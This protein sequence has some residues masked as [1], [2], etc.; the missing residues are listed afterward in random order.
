MNLKN[1]RKEQFK[2]LFDALEEAFQATG[3]DFYVI[4]AMARD[5]WYAK[6]NRTSRMTYDTDF[7]VMVGSIKEF[8]AIKEYLRKNANFV[9]T[10]GNSFVMLSPGGHQVDILPFGGIEIDEAITIAGDG[11]SS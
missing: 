2:E 6:G 11:L 7:A 1:I 5:V 3:T 9:D 4:G 8:E 10:K